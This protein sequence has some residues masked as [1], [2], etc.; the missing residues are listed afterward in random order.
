MARHLRDECQQQTSTMGLSKPTFNNLTQ[1][2]T[3]E[4]KAKHHFC[5]N[6]ALKY[7]NI[8]K[9]AYRFS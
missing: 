1:M 9:D 4:L 2:S 7:L 8:L 3:P 6:E 5:V